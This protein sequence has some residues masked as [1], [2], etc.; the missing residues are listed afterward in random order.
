MAGKW[1]AEASPVLKPTG[2]DDFIPIDPKLSGALAEDGESSHNV[3]TMENIS[4]D[5]PEV[6]QQTGLTKFGENGHQYVKCGTSVQI[7]GRSCDSHRATIT[8]G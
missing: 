4:Q 8:A 5:I 3:L 6:D 7:K 1:E 2:M